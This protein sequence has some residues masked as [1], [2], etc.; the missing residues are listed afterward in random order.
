[1]L[2]LAYNSRSQQSTVVAPLELDTPA[3]VHIFSVKRMVGSS[4]PQ[5]KDGSTR[6]VCGG[7]DPREADWPGRR[8]TWLADRL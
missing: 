3:R 1:M 6:G 5:K 2:T 7:W 8:C 4:A